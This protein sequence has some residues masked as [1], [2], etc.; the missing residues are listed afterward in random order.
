MPPMAR[1]MSEKTRKKN[2]LPP[3][4]YG[5]VVP[6]RDSASDTGSESA[7]HSDSDS[8]SDRDNDI[9]SGAIDGKNENRDIAN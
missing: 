2:S 8:R 5:F 9:E 6:Y 1:F 7:S 3:A 4:R